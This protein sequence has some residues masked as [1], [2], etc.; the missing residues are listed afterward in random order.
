MNGGS[1]EE[2]RGVMPNAARFNMKNTQKVAACLVGI[3]LLGGCATPA[4]DGATTGSVML[5]ASVVPKESVAAERC[6]E[7][8]RMLESRQGTFHRMMVC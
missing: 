2:P 7:S 6:P 8:Y 4:A 5:G 1:G 3:L